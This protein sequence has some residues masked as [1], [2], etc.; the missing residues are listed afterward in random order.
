MKNEK[1]KQI[2]KFVFP[3][4]LSQCAFFVFTIVDGIFVGNGVGS[5][6]LGAVNLALP[7][8][9]IIGALFMFTT[10]GGITLTAIFLGNDQ[11]EKANEVFM[12]S[13]VATLL[14]SLVFSIIGILFTHK[15]VLLLG[16]K[17][18]YI[19]MCSDYVFW[20]SVFTIPS[21][22][23]MTLQ[24]FG[25]ND[26]APVLVS[27]SVIFTT[28]LNIF[29][30]WLF[31]YPLHMKIA[32]AAIATGI[33]QTTGFIILTIYFL[34]K[35]RSLYF[36][37][38]KINKD[39]IKDLSI[40]GLPETISEFA[41]PIT[42]ICM[43]H[44]LFAYLGSNAVNAYSVISYIS[45]FAYAVFLGNAQGF[46][47]LFGQ[48]YGKKNEKDLKYYLKSGII[49]GL[50]GS[51]LVYVLV[52]L[53]GRQVSLLF[54]A[55]IKTLSTVLNVISQYSWAFIPI[56]FNVLISSYLYSIKKAKEATVINFFRGFIVLPVIILFLP[57]LLGTS[58]IW[59]TVGIAKIIIFIFIIF[60]LKNLTKDK[61]W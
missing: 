14:I 48:T 30:D 59:F 39:L 8:T 25:R 46:Q 57:K 49:I 61:C 1:N 16:A 5:N 42:I 38:F 6:A 19:K 9:M 12:H 13:L 26:N 56:S 52:I 58:V 31:I 2:L 23:F 22:L 7:F 20:Y 17:G 11:K 41:T 44:I 51:F 40:Q 28:I 37:K 27:F 43:N 10:M 53:F 50:V 35:K 18:N 32:G 29:L 60:I 47:P 15:L 24:G 45:S 54:G 4:I 3:T 36:G 55:D 21:G 34:M 33:S